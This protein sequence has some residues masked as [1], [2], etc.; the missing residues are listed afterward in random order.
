[1]CVCVCVCVCVCLC[2]HIHAHICMHIHVHVCVCV[3]TNTHTHTHMHTHTHAHI[4][5]HYRRGCGGRRQGHKYGFNRCMIDGPEKASIASCRAYLGTAHE[6][7]CAARAYLGI[8][9]CGSYLGIR[10]GGSN[11]RGG[12]AAP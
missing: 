12:R 5:T 4:H 7:G 6:L 8:R 2:T 11:P 10:V 3:Y 1:M 9:V